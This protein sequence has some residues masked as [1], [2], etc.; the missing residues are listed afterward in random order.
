MG[1]KSSFHL[2]NRQN[3]ICILG[4]QALWINSSHVDIQYRMS[5][6]KS[7][8]FSHRKKK[9]NEENKNHYLWMN[10]ANFSARRFPFNVIIE[11]RKHDFT[12]KKIEGNHSS[13]F[14][15]KCWLNRICFEW[16]S[17]RVHTDFLVPDSNMYRIHMLIHVYIFSFRWNWFFFSL[18]Y[19]LLGFSFGN[20][21]GIYTITP[22]TYK[23]AELSQTRALEMGV[24]WKIYSIKWCTYNNMII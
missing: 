10:G 20:S 15:T 5:Q 22:Y 4:C 23:H 11:I 3:R 14:F 18:C 7:D 8:P 24:P 17:T 6:M 21:Y 13:Y 12:Q 2:L 16:T 1:W 9:W 19:L